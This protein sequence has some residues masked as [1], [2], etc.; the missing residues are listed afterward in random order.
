VSRLAAFQTFTGNPNK[1]ADL[2][3]MYSSLTRE[4]VMNAYNTY[5][6]G[7]NAVVLSVLTK[8]ENTAAAADNFKI[9]SSYYTAP[10]YGYA[11]LKYA[12]GKDNFDRTKQPAVAGVPS[13][14]VPK[15]WRKDLS[16]GAKLIG[17]QNTEI[18]TVTIQLTIPGG[19]LASAN[20]LTKAGLASFFVKMLNEDTKNY[21]A[22]QLSIEL[23]K[24]GSTISIVAGV[25][26]ITYNVQSLKKNFDKTLA[27]LQ[28]KMFNPK[29]DEAAF[30][31]IKSQTLQSF[32]LQKSQPAA[33]ATTV[34]AR[35]NYGDKNIL[36]ISQ[37]G[38]EETVKNISLG[39]IKGY[40]DNYMTA[41]DAKVVVVGDITEQEVLPK[42][43]FLDKLPKKKVTLPGVDPAPAVDKTKVYLVDIPKGAQTEFRVGYATA[44]KYDATGDF[45]KAYLMNYPLGTGF[46]S[47]LNQMLRETKGWTYGAGSGYTGDKYT[48]RFQFSSGIRADVTDSALA[49]VMKEFNDYVKNGPT[50][51]EVKFMQTAVA[52]SDALNYE[53]GFQKA[54]F[55]RRILEYNLPAD[56]VQQ[57][58]KILKGMTAE[59]MK[60]IAGKYLQPDK[61]NILLVGDK[62]KILDG[63]KKLGYE[64]VELDVDGNK[65]DNKKA[66]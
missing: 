52:Q 19:H 17:A 51:E 32:K 7:K 57:Q 37:D 29:F 59:Q 48:G 36:G 60:A 4:D 3:K 33:I 35:V 16:N 25:D 24:L 54:S 28:E 30:N 15:Y 62:A 49:E 41:R 26:G 14:K 20:D 18:P 22:E 6:K 5:I 2:L 27:L 56:F 63:V 23:Q 50:G 38:T 42:L 61:I 13:L 53:T 55:I 65:V 40:Y 64:I 10:D 66:F 43:S 9:D 34:F 44:L 1:I 11:S 8:T 21:T 47:R 58:S 12:K 45:Y 39:D 31:R 46:T